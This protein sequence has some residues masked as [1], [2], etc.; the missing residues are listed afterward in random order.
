MYSREYLIDEF[1]KTRDCT[2]YNNELETIIYTEDMLKSLKSTTKIVDRIN[3]TAKQ[4]DTVSEILDSPIYAAALNFADGYEP[5]GCVLQGAR[6]QE[7]ALCR[8]SNLYESL[9]LPECE[10]EYYKYNSS[11]K[12]FRFGKSSDRIIYT[13]NVAFF[14]DSNL[15]WLDDKQVRHCDIITCPSPTAGTASDEEIKRRMSNIIKVA[16]DNRIT[17]LILGC[18]GCGAFGNDWDKFSQL[19]IDIIKET[20]T[21]CNII[22]AT[23]EKE[24]NSEIL[25][26]EKAYRDFLF[27]C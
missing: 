10:K 6:T 7:E 26:G 17:T 4:V 11:N 16:D 19:W 5:G 12:E 18:W 21:N 14:R 13:K 2:K 1:K 23:N 3:V 20:N 15:N 9:I 22:F 27:D 8:S 24:F 25:W